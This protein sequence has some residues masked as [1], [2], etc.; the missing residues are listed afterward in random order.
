LRIYFFGVLQ[1]GTVEAPWFNSTSDASS[2]E[3]FSLWHNKQ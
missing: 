1:G 3:T 2:K